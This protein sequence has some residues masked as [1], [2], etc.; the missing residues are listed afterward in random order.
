MGT[1]DDIKAKISENLIDNLKKSGDEFVK[2]LDI[3]KN[4][5]IKVIRKSK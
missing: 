4:I 5:K 1:I 2:K 3:F